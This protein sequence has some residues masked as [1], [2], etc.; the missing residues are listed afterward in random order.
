[1]DGGFTYRGVHC[2]TFGLAVTKIEDPLMPPTRDKTEEIDGRDGAWDFGAD[3]G[4]RPVTYV[5]SVMDQTRAS[6]KTNI[7]AIAGWL[8]PKLGEGSLVSDDEPDKYYLARFAGKIPIEQLISAYN[9]FS[10]TFVAYEDPMALG[11]DLIWQELVDVATFKVTNPGTYD[12]KPII[13]IT[14][15]DGEMSGDECLVGAYDPVLVIEDTLTN[16]A[17]T[18]AGQTI[19]YTGTIAPGESLIIDC[20]KGHVTKGGLNA[21]A[22]ISG[23]F[24]VLG[25]GDNNLTMTDE[26]SSNGGLVKVEYNG[27]WL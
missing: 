16:P 17:M 6:L 14:A 11:E 5:V 24:P 12:A 27:R 25:P 7:R 18:I 20:Q 21:N 19:T 22:G 4:P 9:E 8:N 26:S 15:L 23:D 10:I 2:S 3:F 1:M 13:T